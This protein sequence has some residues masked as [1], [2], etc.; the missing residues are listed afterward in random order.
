[1]VVRATDALKQARESI[2]SVSLCEIIC[3]ACVVTL[4]PAH[5]HGCLVV[6]L[7]TAALRPPTAPA[8]FFV[9][10][11]TSEETA[12]FHRCV[13]Q[14]RIAALLVIVCVERASPRLLPLCSYET[15]REASTLRAR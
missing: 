14:S 10:D 8:V 12:L 9:R 6:Q 7:G 11:A 15:R 3:F 1:M 5:L 13:V 2:Q 4:S